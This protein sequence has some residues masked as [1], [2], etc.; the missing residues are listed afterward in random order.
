MRVIPSALLFSIG[1]V[2]SQDL[3]DGGTVA[4][5]TSFSPDD[6]GTDDFIDLDGLFSG[7]FG[8]TSDGDNAVMSG[9]TNDLLAGM[10]GGD[11][12]NGAG[13]SILD[14]FG[15][16]SD[17]GCPASCENQELCKVDIMNLYTIIMSTDRIQQMCDS[18]C[19]PTTILDACASPATSELAAFIAS[20]GVC[21]F[22]NCCVKTEETENVV[23]TVSAT[24]T[25]FDECVA[26]LPGDFIAGSNTVPQDS[27]GDLGDMFGD[28]MTNFDD[29]MSQL[30]DMFSGMFG[31]SS[32]PAFCA[33]DTCDA[34]EGFCECLSGYT[35]ECNKVVITQACASDSFSK[36]APEGFTEEFCTNECGQS[37]GADLYVSHMCAM[38]NVVSCCGDD[39]VQECL[40]DALA[41]DP[42][43]GGMT[44]TAFS[45]DQLQDILGD[46]DLEAMLSDVLFSLDSIK[47]CSE[48][49]K[50][51]EPLMQQFCDYAD[52][53]GSPPADAAES[54]VSHRS[55]DPQ[56]FYSENILGMD[57]DKI[58]SEDMIFGCGP[59]DLK[60]TCNSVCGANDNGDIMKQS[61]C[62]LC[63]IASCCEPG[64]KTFSDCSSAVYIPAESSTPSSESNQENQ[65]FAPEVANETTSGEVAASGEATKP[66][67]TGAVSE[68]TTEVEANNV[69]AD[70]QLEFSRLEKEN[71]GIIFS[72]SSFLN[73]LIF[74]GL[75]LVL[76]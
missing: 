56:S 45:D 66:E 38:C 48:N 12:D 49:K 20:M 32:I 44:M 62:R 21:G 15:E 51:S 69:A 54:A 5:T 11:D 42:S 9:G 76:N 13:D 74:T 63:G 43:Q 18:G 53:N 19:I 26:T 59:V 67:L 39:N 7:I 27:F 2:A 33:V 72:S 23:V 34:P 17:L 25:K 30:E 41:A 1:N 73:A 75:V 55:T 70:P 50:C 29:I 37:S 58:C 10:F 46:V 68:G 65:E 24:R 28:M 16:A 8:D 22:V 52:D 4:E 64:G 61:F 6:V 40:L 35:T 14:M 60:A 36:C 31:S 3:V 47:W 71:S 57:L